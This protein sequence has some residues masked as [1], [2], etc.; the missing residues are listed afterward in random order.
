MLHEASMDARF[1][2]LISD[3]QSGY[4]FYKHGFG[5]AVHG[6]NWSVD[7]DFGE[8]GQIDGVDLHRLRTFAEWN[9]SKY[10]FESAEEIGQLFADAVKHDSLRFSGYILYYVW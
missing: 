4:R 7:F 6:P 3:Y 5:C 8:Q 2:K 10:G 9:L 1:A